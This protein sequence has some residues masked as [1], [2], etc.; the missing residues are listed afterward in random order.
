M[1][2]LTIAALAAVVSLGLWAVGRDRTPDVDPIVS[3]SIPAGA[4][5]HSYTITN[6]VAKTACLAERGAAISGRSTRFTA[7]PDCDAVWP[8]LAGAR[9]WTQN[10]DGTVDVLDARGE[11]L[12]TV[13]DGDGLAYE[14]VEPANAMVT[15]V[16]AD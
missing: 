15:F 5:G 3:S 12:L 7:D 8:G 1:K 11:A 9:T 14:A 16:A 4:A 10:G 6:S 2:T 13:V